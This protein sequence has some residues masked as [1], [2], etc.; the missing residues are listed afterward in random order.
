MHYKASVEFL[1]P[2]NGWS[3]FHVA[4]SKANVEL[5]KDIV[6]SKPV[7]LDTCTMSGDCG[8]HIAAASNL[9]IVVQ[10]LA[11]LGANINIQNKIGKS[12]LMIAIELRHIDIVNYLLNKTSIV[13]N[14]TENVNNWNCLTFACS[15]GMLPVA[16]ELVHRDASLLDSR[17]FHDISLLHVAISANQEEICSFLLE[18]CANV[19]FPRSDNGWTPL[20]SAVHSGNEVLVKMLLKYNAKTRINDKDKKDAYFYAV[21]YKRDGIIRIL[22]PYFESNQK[23]RTSSSG[24]LIS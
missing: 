10:T 21:Q 16:M 22:K 15:S 20:I 23:G 11:E 6:K 4:C 8:L 24:C 13:L 12:A 17:A 3:S 2:L 9:L 14:L 5:I 19:D 18:K 1:N 7:M